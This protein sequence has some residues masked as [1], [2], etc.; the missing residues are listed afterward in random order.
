MF[1][2]ITTVAF[3]PENRNQMVIIGDGTIDAAGLA[4]SLRKKLGYA[5]LVS[6]EQV[7]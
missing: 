6:V 2:G 7:K 3:K 4:L 5:G 1:A